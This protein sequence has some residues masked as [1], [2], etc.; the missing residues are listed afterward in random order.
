MKKGKGGGVMGVKERLQKMLVPTQEGR[1]SGGLSSNH[2]SGGAGV[3][4]IS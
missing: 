3:A 1:S 4:K 2:L